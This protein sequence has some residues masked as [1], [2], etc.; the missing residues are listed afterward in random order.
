M[1]IKK[2]RI[3]MIIKVIITIAY[4]TVLEGEASIA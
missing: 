4:P 3:K 1:I 2:V